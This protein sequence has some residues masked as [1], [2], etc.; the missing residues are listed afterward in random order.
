MWFI[1]S[2]IW[3]F[4]ESSAFSCSEFFFFLI[5]RLICN[6]IKT[7]LS[8]W[9]YIYAVK[10]D[11]MRIE[12]PIW[13]WMFDSRPCIAERRMWWEFVCVMCMHADARMEMRS[14]FRISLG[15]NWKSIVGMMAIGPS[16]NVFFSNH[17]PNEIVNETR[18]NAAFIWREKLRKIQR[19][20][21][22][23]AFGLPNDEGDYVRLYSRDL[24][25]VHIDSTKVCPF[26][27]LKIFIFYFVSTKNIHNRNLNVSVIV[28]YLIFEAIIV[29]WMKIK[30][31]KIAAI[32]G[33]HSTQ[34]LSADR[35]KKRW[36]K[37][38]I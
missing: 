15:N 9:A 13:R 26:I 31:E 37:T 19:T 23:H 2:S 21:L 4:S 11:C 30:W 24:L 18:P 17:R 22:W 29:R 10:H 3:L 6:N 33:R 36:P 1:S 8:Q 27:R 7:K 14:Y 34:L 12:I 35:E 38:S 20:R 28:R 25:R 16:Q 32:D 5:W